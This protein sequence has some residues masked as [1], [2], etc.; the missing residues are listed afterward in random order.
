MF[1]PRKHYIRPH[2]AAFVAATICHHLHVPVRV[3]QF[4]ISGS[5]LS[6]RNHAR[7]VAVALPGFFAIRMAKRT[8]SPSQ[9]TGVTIFPLD[10][11]ERMT[12]TKN[13]SRRITLPTV[14]FV[15]SEIA[16]ISVES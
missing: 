14:A 5:D 1:N 4:E 9:S 10:R 2:R 12:L 15:A 16:L 11:D 7:S 13:V 8:D 6:A 3:V